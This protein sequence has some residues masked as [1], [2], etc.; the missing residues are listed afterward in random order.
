MLDTASFPSWSH[1]H[2]TDG[3]PAPRAISE[4]ACSRAATDAGSADSVKRNMIQ[5]MWDSTGRPLLATGPKALMQ[6]KVVRAPM[7]A[8]SATGR[9]TP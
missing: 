7:L 9:L 3:D 1:R 4:I 6:L 2:G 5:Q 8:A